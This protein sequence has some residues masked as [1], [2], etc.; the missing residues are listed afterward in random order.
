MGSGSGALRSVLRGAGWLGGSRVWANR[1]ALSSP[2]AGE[3]GAAV[4]GQPYVFGGWTGFDRVNT[5]E[6]LGGDSAW[7]PTAPF[8]GA[9]RQDIG[10]TAVGGKI[11]LV[12]GNTY[13]FASASWIDF[14][15]L[16]RYAPG[17]DTWK[18]L[19]HL[20]RPLSNAAVVA[21]NGYLYV[22]GGNTTPD[23]F[24]NAIRSSYRYNISTNRW[25][26]L[27]PMPTP[28]M[29]ARAAVVGTRAYVVGGRN[30][31]G[32]EVR[33]NEAYSFSTNRWVTRSPLAH[34]RDSLVVRVGGD[35]AIYAIGGWGAGA[36]AT[37]GFS[38]EVNRYVPST[39]S[40]TRLPD[41]PAPRAAAAS[42]V[43]NGRIYVLGGND[44]AD[45]PSQTVGVLTTS[46]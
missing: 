22:F 18:T 5:G 33:V 23:L 19:A 24:E 3:A 35:G 45:S 13:D 31:S 34:G 8:P 42:A 28:R 21:R 32:G 27:A 46:R 29:G 17:S 26:T 6:F 9:G 44:A 40:W 14:N 10:A 20:P 43:I 30:S 38:R 37:N 12:G 36:T 7:H 1:P 11:Y 16:L 15:T 4:S 41:A 25:T 2:R 39:N